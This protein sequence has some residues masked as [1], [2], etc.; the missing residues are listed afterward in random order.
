MW[1]SR[2]EPSL[3]SP[4]ANKA[5]V[6]RSCGLGLRG[7]QDLLG[8]SPIQS[9]SLG[10]SRQSEQQKGRNPQTRGLVA[11]KESLTQSHSESKSKAV[12]IPFRAGCIDVPAVFSRLL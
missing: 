7:K 5:Q 8:L 1:L 4:E 2:E 11:R 10:L 12:G 9:V 3:E 6:R